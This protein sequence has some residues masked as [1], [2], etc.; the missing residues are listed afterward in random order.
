MTDVDT[1]RCQDVIAEIIHTKN[2]S[3][4]ARYFIAYGTAKDRKQIV[5]N[6]KPHLERICRDGEAQLVLFTLLDVTDD[7]KLL[8]KSLLSDLTALTPKL[9]MDANG[10]R[11]LLYPLIGRNKRHMTPVIVDTL[12]STDSIREKTSKKDEEVR[13]DEVRKAV[14]ED[15]LKQVRDHVDKLIVDPGGS[16]LVT[17]VLLH[18]D[19]GE[20]FI[21]LAFSNP[22]FFC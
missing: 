3:L 10:R 22:N 1:Y 12:K 6:L 9:Y 20:P 7:T 21:S 16:L 8:S 19:G 11:A 17:E 15:M 4:I 2:G 14:S 13:R 18:A 5:K